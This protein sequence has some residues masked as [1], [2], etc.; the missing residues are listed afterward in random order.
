MSDQTFNS[1]YGM[2]QHPSLERLPYSPDPKSNSWV[3][4]KIWGHRIEKQHPQLLLLEFL[5]MAE[6]MKRQGK[7]LDSS[8]DTYTPYLCKQLR[9]I[10]FKN[11]QLE[12]ISQEFQNSN[13]AWDAWLIS[14]ESATDGSLNDFNFLRERFGDFKDFVEHVKLLSRITVQSIGSTQWNRKRIAPIGPAALYDER[15]T[16]FLRTRV[17]F[18]RTGEL[19][20]LMLTRAKVFREEIH[21]WLSSAFDTETEKN[22]LL[23]SLMKDFEPDLTPE[24]KGGTY[25]P[26]EWE[27]SY[28]KLAED[29]H[30]LFQLKLPPADTFNLLAPLLAFHVMLYQLYVAARIQSLENP[31]TIVCEILAPRTSQVRKASVE[32]LA[33]NEAL[34]LQAL[35]SHLLSEE[36]NDKEVQKVLT[37]QDHLEVS[38]IQ[39]FHEKLSK[40]FILRK[41]PAQGPSIRE[42]REKIHAAVKDD[43]R[44]KANEGFRSMSDGAGLR[45]RKKTN[46]Y[47]YCASDEFLRNMVYV[48]VT[49]PMKETD[50]L[51]KLHAKYGLVIGEEEARS[52]VRDGLFQKNEF[53]KNGE[54]LINQLAA[55]GLARRM[56]DSFTYIINPIFQNNAS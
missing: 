2:S 47:R 9:T 31:P 51:A 3:S 45:S 36:A 20:Y 34:L 1:N 41:L 56:S 44:K 32:S 27:E 8:A 39:E 28:D 7:L 24:M 5:S 23:C 11:A 26:Y 52:A 35:E 6:G 14:M 30:A 22:R 10:L 38:T 49:V 46:R 17:D 12:E 4:E 50:F 29:V 37:E 18:T 19:V 55:M 54:R 53:K 25:L 33:K 15:N 40:T 42:T 16:S 13:Q 43:F 48:T 21:A